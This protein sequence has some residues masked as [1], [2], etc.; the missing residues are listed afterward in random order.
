MKKIVVV[1]MLFALAFAGI[2]SAI[3]EPVCSPSITLLN[4]DPYPGMPNSY[5]K[6]VFMITGVS[7]ANCEKGA[8]VKLIPSYPFSLD[9]EE[10]LRTLDSNTFIANQN[11]NWMVPFRLRVDK[12]AL[13]GEYDLELRY[14]ANGI[15]SPTGSYHVEFFNVTL[16]DSRTNF[17]ALIQEVNGQ[18]VT[19]ALANS[20]KNVANSVVVRLPEQADF[21]PVGTD[22]QMVGNLA[23]GDYTV[24]GFTVAPKTQMNRQNMTRDQMQSGAPFAQGGIKNLVLDI[25]YTDSLG[26]RRIISKELPLDM[27]GAV[28][29]TGFGGT[30]AARRPGTTE[31]ASHLSSM[32]SWQMIA[33]LLIGAAIM[34]FVAKKVYSRKKAH[35]A[36]NEVPDWAKERK[37]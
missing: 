10:A 29:M 3:G 19:I 20:G 34:F 16:V 26:E 32:F 8:W 5:V 23:S 27:R 18:D 31:T 25:Y 35:A 24:V 11:S 33:A 4:Q 12:D 9:G 1:V 2:V 28:N 17:D 36:P 13:E 15:S 7:G 6:L 21:R 37:K 22:G 30:F 14:G